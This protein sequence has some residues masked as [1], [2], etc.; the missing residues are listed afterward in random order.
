[1]SFAR[2]NNTEKLIVISNFSEGPHRFRFEL[3]PSV[4]SK[5]NLNDGEYELAD[6]LYQKKSFKLFVQ[7][8]KAFVDIQI[9]SLESFIL[10]LQ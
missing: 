5:W 3:S 7:G 6:Q 10:K 1:M 8:E 2:W 4:L 9:G